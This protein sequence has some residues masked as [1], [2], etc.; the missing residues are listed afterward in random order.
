[1]GYDMSMYRYDRFLQ[2][3]YYIENYAWAMIGINSSTA[4]RDQCIGND[5]YQMF[6]CHKIMYG[7][8]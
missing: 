2:F 8:L 4:I 6:I 5:R 1:M 3:T 7:L